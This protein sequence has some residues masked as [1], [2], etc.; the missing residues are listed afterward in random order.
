MLPTVAAGDT[1]AARA[2]LERALT[3][4]PNDPQARRVLDALKK[5]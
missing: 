4:A 5:P 1:T 2:S 3:V